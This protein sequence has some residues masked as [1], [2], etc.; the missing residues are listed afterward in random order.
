MPSSFNDPA[1]LA[2]AEWR[3]CPMDPRY[4]VC[5]LGAVRNRRTGR[6]LKPWRAGAGYWYV[7]IGD[8]FE[9][10]VHRLVALTFLGP[11]PTPQ[12]EVAHNDGNRDN[13][14]AGNLRWATHAENMADMRAHGTVVRYWLGRRP[15]STKLQQG[16]IVDIRQRAAS[17][18]PRKQLAS[19]FGVCRATIDHIV[20]RRSWSDLS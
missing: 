8:G 10:G 9:T 14:S 16:Q 20:Q 7:G 15:P 5:A 19:E 1:A 12:H 13:N 3:P 4:E 17:G 6:V 18:V 11:A 2:E